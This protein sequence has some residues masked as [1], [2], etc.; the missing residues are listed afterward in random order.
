LRQGDLNNLIRVSGVVTRRTG[1]FPQLKSVAYD[2]KAC[3][4]VL[5]PFRITNAEVRPTSCI[6]CQQKGP[7]SINNQKSEYGNYQKI[8][9]QESPGSVPAGR[10][11]R[12]KD[13]ILLGDLIDI[14]RPG[15]EIEVTGI[16]EHSQ[17][18]VSKDKNGFP[19]FSTVIQANNIQKKSGAS[20]TDLSDEDKR[21]IRELSND[22]Q[23]RRAHWEN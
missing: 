19:V 7:F 3:G 8:T 5:G 20:N 13:V 1:V 18:G 4:Q 15:E 17:I 11:P 16:Y 10:V 14:A 12:Y 6:S 21:M 9:L 23:V 2:C 22:P